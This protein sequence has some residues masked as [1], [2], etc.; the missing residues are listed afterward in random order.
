MT[1]VECFD[2]FTL[3]WDTL[4]G[5]TVPAGVI[6]AVSIPPSLL[7]FLPSLFT[8]A[9]VRNVRVG[10]DLRVNYRSHDLVRFI[11]MKGARV[12]TKH[13]TNRPK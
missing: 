7:F 10:P 12:V 13:F 4:V 1:V 8:V 9:H 5:V 6:V 3:I 2:K 11:P